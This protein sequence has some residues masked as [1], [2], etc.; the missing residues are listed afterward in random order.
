MGFFLQ[1][2]AEPGH[3]SRAYVYL[4]DFFVQQHGRLPLWA[5]VRKKI[6][7]NIQEER[8]CQKAALSNVCMSASMRKRVHTALSDKSKLMKTG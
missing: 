3:V 2:A 4:D 1:P 8:P 6:R 5:S 7:R